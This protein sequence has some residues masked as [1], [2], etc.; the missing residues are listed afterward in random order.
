[1]RRCAAVEG[2][3]RR[4]QIMCGGSF[5]DVRGCWFMLTL[6]QVI[7]RLDMINRSDVRQLDPCAAA[8]F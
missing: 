7:S 1:M 8:E 6:I 2:Y 4:Q 3:V 5:V